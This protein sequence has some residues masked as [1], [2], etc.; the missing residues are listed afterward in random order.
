M[1]TFRTTNCWSLGLVLA[2]AAATTSGQQP[3]STPPQKPPQ[4]EEQ[5]PIKT[6]TEEVQLP[7]A[8]F[9]NRGHPDPTL[10]LDDIMVLEDGVPQEIKSARRAPASVLLLLDTGGELNS[11]KNIRVTRAIARQLVSGLSPQD[12]ISV[13]QFNNK[14]EL[15]QDWTKDTKLVLQ[16]LDTKLSAGKRAHFSAAILSASER[17]SDRPVGNRHLVMITDGVETPGGLVDRNE[18]LKRL[19]ASNTVVHVISYTVVSRLPIEQSQRRVRKRDKSTVPDEVVDTLPNDD[20]YRQLKELHKPGGI[21]VDLDPDRRRQIKE[22]EAAMRASEWQ[23]VSLARETGGHIWLPESFAE[24]VGD[25]TEAARLIDAEYVVTYRP[26]RPLA[27]A[28]AGEVR[29]ID[30]VSRRV[31]LNLV[32]RRFYVVPA[33]P[34]T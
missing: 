24:M 11:A 6:V 12:Q 25:G 26:K 22:Y 4:Q 17:L 20:G 34:R 21:I 23:L 2:C 8:V 1:S 9:D 16:V 13:M 19:T 29:R 3:N 10:E 28:R 15:L 18:A 14:S 5:E 31:G 32:A 30:V 27:A 33:K 7:V